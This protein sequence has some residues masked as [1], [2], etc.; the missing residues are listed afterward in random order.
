[1]DSGEFLDD[2]AV[3]LELGTA[4]LAGLLREFGDARVATAAYNAGPTR[5]REWWGARRSADLDVWVEQIPYDETRAFV[6]RVMLSWDEYRRLYGGS[7][8][9]PPDASQKAAPREE[10]S[11]P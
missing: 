11:K 5:V 7:L 10:N 8:T 2:P 3:N 9:G 6:K 4:Y 1:V